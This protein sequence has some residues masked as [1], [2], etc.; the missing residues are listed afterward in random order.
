MTGGGQAP[1]FEAPGGLSSPSSPGSEPRS[2]SASS[3]DSTLK[4][5]GPCPMWPPP[6]APSPSM[7]MSNV[8]RAMHGM[9]GA[10]LAARL[11]LSGRSDGLFCQDPGLGGSRAHSA[12]YKKV[13]PLSC[14]ATQW[15]FQSM[16]G[17]QCGLD[18]LLS[19]AGP[20][21]RGVA[22]AWEPSAPRPEVALSHPYRAFGTY[23]LLWGRL[24]SSS[25]GK[26]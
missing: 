1:G 3:S 10:G 9:A 12:L 16:C 17:P 2:R 8:A 4:G 11:V 15:S 18:S 22:A 7:F 14:A 24:P 25:C 13:V 23:C 26:G 20:T 6:R 21:G 5:S 19:G